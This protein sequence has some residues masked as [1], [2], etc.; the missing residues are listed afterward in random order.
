MK[1]VIIGII[2]VYQVIFSPDKGIFRALYPSR[3]GCVMYPTCSEY[4][5]LAIWKYGS[6]KG[7]LRG[8][9]RIGR[10]HPFQKKLVDMP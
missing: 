3:G 9:A 1:F 7:V 8:I 6:V 4:M 2:R 10:C 5:I